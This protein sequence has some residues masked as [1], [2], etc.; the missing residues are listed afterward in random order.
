MLTVGSG[1]QLSAALRGS[2]TEASGWDRSADATVRGVT[3]L[4]DKGRPEPPLRADETATL[5]AFLEWQRATLAW[6]CSG[7]DAAGLAATVSTSSMSLGGLWKHQA[8][9][10]DYWFS[11]QLLGRDAAEPW[12]SVDWTADPDWEWHSAADDTAEQLRAL[13]EESVE[14]SRAAVAEALDA[15]GLDGVVRRPPPDVE[16]ASLRGSYAI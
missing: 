10:E 11:R 12:D 2:A 13:W 5:L 1:G 7:V 14:R 3:D 16:P 9:S 8:L 4:D 6:K 15:G